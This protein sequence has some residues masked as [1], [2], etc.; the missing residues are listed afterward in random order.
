ML[1]ISKKLSEIFADI[2]GPKRAEIFW[3]WNGPGRAG[4]KKVPNGPGRAEKFRP[5]DI[6]NSLNRR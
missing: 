4:P 5:V 1:S 3:K 2:N 6:S